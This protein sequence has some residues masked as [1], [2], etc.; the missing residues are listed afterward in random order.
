MSHV[1]VIHQLL[2]QLVRT[3][4]E[5]ERDETVGPVNVLLQRLLV[6]SM[7]PSDCALI[8]RSAEWP[9]VIEST[10]N[11]LRRPLSS[12]GDATVFCLKA[13]SLVCNVCV[14]EDIR[15]HVGAD[16]LLELCFVALRVFPTVK[17][18]VHLTL[19]TI[20]NIA[21]CGGVSLARS[22]AT[23][24]IRSLARMYQEGPVAEAWCTAVCNLAGS[25]GANL[26]VLVEH[27]AVEQ[28]QRLLLFHGDSERVVARGIQTL[29]C[30]CA[31]HLPV[32]AES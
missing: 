24:L 30:L 20:A 8:V 22:D 26:N 28:V 32:E 25:T 6:H 17:R 14:F 7:H 12:A 15:P 3:L 16:A 5:A 31:A 29:S 2:E 19:S 23:C 11:A 10:C 1:H 4:G 13:V 18:L 27:N 21:L 9:V